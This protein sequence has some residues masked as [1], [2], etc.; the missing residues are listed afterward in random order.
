MAPNVIE[1][2]G[3]TLMVSV[4][5]GE[6][7]PP[8]VTVQLYTPADASVAGSDMVDPVAE[9]LAGPLQL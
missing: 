5:G 4:V 7:I 9:K 1:G 6:V 8:D 2:S 3:C